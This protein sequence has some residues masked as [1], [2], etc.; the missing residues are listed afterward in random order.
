MGM[1]LG[2]S[3]MAM[4]TLASMSMVSGRAKAG[5]TMPMGVT[6]IG[7]DSWHKNQ[8]TGPDRAATTYKNGC[9]SKVT[10]QTVGVLERAVAKD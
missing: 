10:L 3:P 5:F 1:E 8:M 4:Y 7:A 2:G 6:C 9:V